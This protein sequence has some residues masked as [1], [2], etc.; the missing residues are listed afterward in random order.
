MAASPMAMK[1]KFNNINEEESIH[2]E[3]SPTVSTAR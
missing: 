1:L 3:N 2:K